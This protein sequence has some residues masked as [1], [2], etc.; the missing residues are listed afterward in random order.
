MHIQP[1]LIGSGYPVAMAEHAETN[2]KA[3]P[4]WDLWAG[5]RANYRKL[6]EG[7]WESEGTGLWTDPSI[8]ILF[9]VFLGHKHIPIQAYSTVL[10]FVL[11]PVAHWK[12]MVLP[13][14]PMASIGTTP[15]HKCLVK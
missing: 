9:L 4:A 13:L 12:K 11:P 7:H 10:W 5:L 6:P 2:L 8:H 3:R 1:I 14:H 15:G